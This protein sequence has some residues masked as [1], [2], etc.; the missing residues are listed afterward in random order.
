LSFIASSA[1]ARQNCGMQIDK[2]TQR[3]GADYTNFWS[4]SWR[5]CSRE[6]VNDQRCNA[7]DYD[8]NSRICYLKD[9]IPYPRQNWSIVSGVKDRQNY[10][11]ENSIDGFR[12][13]LG[14]ARNGSDYV[15]FV[16]RSVRQCAIACDE[17]YRCRA[18]DFNKNDR[19]CYL[20]DRVPA[21]HQNRA[22]ISGVK[23][24]D[25][26]GGDGGYD[27]SL[28]R[29]PV[30]AIGHFQGHN[31]RD[32]T[33]AS[34]II[35]SS[36]DVSARWNGESHRGYFDGKNLTI[37]GLDFIVRQRGD[38]IETILRSDRGNRVYFNRQRY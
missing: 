18:F 33:P 1:T 24:D 7:F 34:I 20:K 30:W 4:K 5:Q 2:D 29:I 14:L 19:L 31:K 21:L 23:Q 9:R 26:Y 16:A 17:D 12:L 8:K 15:R 37:N 6:C 3:P 38:G 10:G 36:G 27:S 28:S 35:S 22:V 11:R 32:R 13:E 25:G